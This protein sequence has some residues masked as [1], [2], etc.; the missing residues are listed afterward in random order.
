[1]RKDFAAKVRKPSKKVN[2]GKP[3]KKTAPRKKTGPSFHGPSFSAGTIL[4]AIIVFLMAYAPEIFIDNSSILDNIENSAKKP[5]PKIEIT[6]PTILKESQV[7]ADTTLYKV[8]PKS[9]DDNSLRSDFLYQAASFRD[10]LDA[11]KL[12]AKLLLN[13]LKADIK[14]KTLNKVKWHRVLVGPFEDKD[15]ADKAILK[16]RELSVPAIQVT[17]N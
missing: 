12:R 9:S 8:T 15:S 2:K 3:K 5:E 1:M 13:N 6:F 11:Q 7:P 16:L 10:P 4:G 14:I 17:N